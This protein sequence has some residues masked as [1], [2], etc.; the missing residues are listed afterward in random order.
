MIAVVALAGLGRRIRNGRWDAT[1]AVLAVAPVA[2]LAGGAYGGEAVFRVYLFALPFLVFFAAACCYPTRAHE[3]ARSAV[4][5]VLVSAITLTGFLFGYFGKEQWTHFTVGE[6]VFDGAPPRS[7]VVDGSGDY[8]V[9]FANFEHVTYLDLVSEPPAEIDALLA[10]PEPFLYGWL[11]DARYSRAYLIITRSQKLE[12]DAL[13]QL[14]R[15]EK[16]LLA[17]PRFTVLY[18]DA[19][20]SA[21]TVARLDPGSQP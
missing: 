16:A 21:F 17:S 19:D 2:I 7:L 10:A 20:A 13:G 3:R 5:A 8:P 9:G 18:H 6:A 14:D 1:A 11:T 12:S 15:I 4:L